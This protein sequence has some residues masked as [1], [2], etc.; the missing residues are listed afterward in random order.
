MYEPQ[1]IFTAINNHFGL[2]CNSSLPAI[3]QC[4]C[5]SIS[6]LSAILKHLLTH[7]EMKVWNINSGGPHAELAS[8]LACFNYWMLFID[9]FVKPACSSQ[10]PVNPFR[11]RKK[12]C[13]FHIDILTL[14]FYPRNLNYIFLIFFLMKHIFLILTQEKREYISNF[15]QERRR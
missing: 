14:T 8:L 3:H 1:F 11:Q 7:M 5:A 2:G 6:T 12:N 10:L 9:E 15:S 4:F 13:Y